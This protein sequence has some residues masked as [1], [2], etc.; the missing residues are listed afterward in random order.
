[1]SA[2]DVTKVRA[3]CVSYMIG[4]SVVAGGLGFALGAWLL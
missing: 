2:A 3:E 4:I 1:M